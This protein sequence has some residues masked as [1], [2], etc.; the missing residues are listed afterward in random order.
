MQTPDTRPGPYYV[1]AIMDGTPYLMAGPYDLHEQALADVERARGIA[2]EVDR[3]SVW[4]AFG[5][6]RV[7]GQSKP[8]ALNTHGLI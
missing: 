4:A 7:P 8:G 2:C 3:R 6:C 1:S 5:T